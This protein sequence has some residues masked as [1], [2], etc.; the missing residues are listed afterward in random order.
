VSI[1]HPSRTL[2]LRA[3]AVAAVAIAAVT[4]AVRL[5]PHAAP[6]GTVDTQ[7]TSWQLPR[8]GG[9]GQVTLASF[10]GHPLVVDFFASWCTACQ[11][12]L[13]G[14]ATVSAELKGKVTF[15]GVDSEETGNGLAMAQRYGIDWWPLA[16]DSGGAENS[17]LHDDLGALGMPVMAFYDGGG[18]LLTVVPGAIS[19]T[20]LRTRLHD[21]FGIA[22]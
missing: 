11:G 8:L 4:V 19:E 9:P 3:A 13:P 18:R 16:V 1:R 6:A 7:R 17:G 22:S 21:L 14:L 2:A 20:D 10:R 12:E 15:A 5:S